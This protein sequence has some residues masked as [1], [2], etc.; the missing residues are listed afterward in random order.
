[1]SNL[2]VPKK[3]E[4]PPFIMFAL[5]R[6]KS[7]EGAPHGL[8]RQLPQ[9]RDQP[10]HQDEEGEGDVVVSERNGVIDA[11]VLERASEGPVNFR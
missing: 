6:V 5:L 1:M 3:L 10:D 9:G 2:L 7:S 4:H 8:H 11:A